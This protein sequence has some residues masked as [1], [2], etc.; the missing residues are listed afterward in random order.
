MEE[1]IT[2]IKISAEYLYLITIGNKSQIDLLI[3]NMNLHSKNNTEKYYSLKTHDSISSF[4]NIL[5]KSND[6]ISSKKHV[7]I[8]DGIEPAQTYSYA[9]R[10]SS[11]LYMLMLLTEH[12]DNY[13]LSFPKFE[14][15][16]EKDP[17]EQI[18]SWFKNKANRIP[19]GLF[20]NLK[21]I[22]VVGNN[23]NILVM[24]TRLA[25]KQKF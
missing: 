17:D 25:K 7:I 23:S 8:D 24:S 9:D 5:N 20:K 22:T 14:L 4:C 21:V 15:N 3:N 1:N 16:N 18:E 13:V 19:K 12:E 6:I 11:N 10:T 2:V